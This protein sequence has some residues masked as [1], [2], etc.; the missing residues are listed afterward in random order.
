M[1][2]A[3]VNGFFPADHTHTNKE[4]AEINAQKVVDGIKDLKKCK[5][6]KYLR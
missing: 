3:K 1:D 5:L 6:K 4:G 2:T